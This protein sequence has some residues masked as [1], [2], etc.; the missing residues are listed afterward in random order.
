MGKLD[1]LVK[2]R[3]I[4]NHYFRAKIDN[5]F[6]LHTKIALFDALNVLGPY[7]VPR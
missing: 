4:N 7:I 2:K 3:I 6:Q 1:I 5:Q